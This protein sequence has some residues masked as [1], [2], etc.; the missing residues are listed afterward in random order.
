MVVALRCLFLAACALCL[1]RAAWATRAVLELT[2]RADGSRPDIL[3]LAPRPVDDPK[4]Y[5][6]ILAQAR[7]LGTTLPNASLT[8]GDFR[9]GGPLPVLSAA[10][11]R[12]IPVQDLGWTAACA[13]LESMMKWRGVSRDED[14]VD[15][16]PTCVLLS[17][18]ATAAELA[19]T[20]PALLRTDAL[21]LLAPQGEGQPVIVCWRN[22]VW[23][24]HVAPQTIRPD[25]WVPTLSEIVGLP[26][27]AEVDAVSIL[28]LLTGVGYQRP[29][30]PAVAAGVPASVAAGRQYAMLSHF[31]ELPKSC[32]WVPDFTDV[33]AI[34]PDERL[35]LPSTV[36]LPAREAT[37]FGTSR[38][39]QGF[40]VRT[41]QRRLSLTFP[42]GVSCVIRVK[43]RPV[44]SVWRPKGT[45]TWRL[46]GP[47]AVPVEIFIVLPPRLDPAALPIFAPP[48]PPA[49]KA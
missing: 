25:H 22:M 24:G 36:P 42:A 27:P 41:T 48:D 1:T 8:A 28:P 47:D 23:P 35:F 33:A 21:I 10:G 6:P 46:D 34:K 31:A 49:P 40:Y 44:H 45:T 16:P 19:A 39:D 2:G 29:I 17:E 7:A 18:E 20:L 30:E 14:S 32:P 15:L 12:L 3:F 13:Q 4:A 43:G 5:A 37:R 26:P 38:H 11:Y 9:S